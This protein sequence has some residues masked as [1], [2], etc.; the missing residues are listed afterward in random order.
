MKVSGAIRTKDLNTYLN[1]AR[2]VDTGKD[3]KYVP[4]FDED[5]LVDSMG[6]GAYAANL[7]VAYPQFGDSLYSTYAYVNNMTTDLEKDVIVD[8]ICPTQ[9]VEGI[10]Y[11]MEINIPKELSL[12][13]KQKLFNE[14]QSAGKYGE[15]NAYE[16]S[17]QKFLIRYDAKYNYRIKLE[18]TE[19]TE[20]SKKPSLNEK[21]VNNF[22]F[23]DFPVPEGSVSMSYYFGGFSNR[24]LESEYAIDGEDTE[25]LFIS[26]SSVAEN[27]VSTYFEALEEYGLTKYDEVKD[28][29][30]QRHIIYQKGNVNIDMLITEDTYEENM[31]TIFMWIYEGALITPSKVEEKLQDE[32]GE[33]FDV[34]S[35]VKLSGTYD[36]DYTIYKLREYAGKFYSEENP[37]YCVTLDTKTNIFNS[38]C[39]ALIDMGYK[40]YRVNNFPYTYITRGQPHYV[41]EKD[42]VFCDVAIYHTSDYTYMGHKEFE[43]RLEVLIYTGEPMSVDTYDDLSVLTKLYEEIDPS[44]A[45]YPELPEDAVVEVWRDLGDFKLSSVTYG[46]GNRDEAFVYTEYVDEAYEAVKEAALEAGFKMSGERTKSALFSKTIDGT[47]YSILILKEVEKGYLRVMNDIGGVDFF[48]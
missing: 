22:G 15:E 41:F 28:M 5:G 33:W 20:V 44:L 21:I 17:L 1:N 25:G 45:Y 14:L 11:H 34:S 26:F 32:I 43:Y 24:F 36:A 40:S 42:G 30:D 4:I 9:E 46:F 47:L 31:Y 16:L 3:N 38:Y 48:I 13:K 37:L 8:L 23:E 12:E 39:E 27:V 6:G 10:Y 7:F 35:F 19:D 18:A 2:V 29:Y